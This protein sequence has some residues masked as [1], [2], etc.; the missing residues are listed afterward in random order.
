MQIAVASKD[1]KSVAGHIGK[2]ADWIIFEVVEDDSADLQFETV[3][4]AA[5][6]IKKRKK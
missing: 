3:A 1:G 5:K 2:C 6:R 4:R